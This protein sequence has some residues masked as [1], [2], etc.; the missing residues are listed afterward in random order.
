MQHYNTGS[1]KVK[2]EEKI[3]PKKSVQGLNISPYRKEYVSQP[4]AEVSFATCRGSDPDPRRKKTEAPYGTSG[5]FG[6]PRGIQQVIFL[7]KI[8]CGSCGE[9]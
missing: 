3:S 8:T 7:R 5:I 9:V 4:S 2:R 1:G 6:P